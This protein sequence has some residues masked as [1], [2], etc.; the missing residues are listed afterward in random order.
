MIEPNLGLPS[1]RRLDEPSTEAPH[2]RGLGV[3]L[4]AVFLEAVL[5]DN[6]AIGYPAQS[7]AGGV[8]GIFAQPRR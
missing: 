2:R 5:L 4:E 6:R 1:A 7:V 8:H 3:F